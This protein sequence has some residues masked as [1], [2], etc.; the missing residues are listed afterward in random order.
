MRQLK[1]CGQNQL[2]CFDIRPLFLECYFNAVLVLFRVFVVVLFS[3]FLNVRVL[4]FGHL[5]LKV[6]GLFDVLLVVWAF[7]FI[8]SRAHALPG[9]LAFFS[10]SD[11]RSGP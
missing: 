11:I 5:S 4:C 1:E 2:G 7:R 9:S 3:E 10:L 6:D 8:K